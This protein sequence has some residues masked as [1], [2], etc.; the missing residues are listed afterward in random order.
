M[1][2]MTLVLMAAMMLTTI[3]ACKQD[4]YGDWF[5]PRE[6]VT[7]QVTTEDGQVLPDVSLMTEELDA[8]DNDLIV[9]GT[10]HYTTDAE[11]KVTVEAP[12][13]T[14]SRLSERTTRFTFTATDYAIF[15]TIFNYWDGTVDIVLHR[16]EL[17]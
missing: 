16:E 15:D 3:S 14:S 10:H 7:F 6:S 4:V 1:R 2:K 13:Y 17:N 8:F 12:Y 5:V 11:G 9:D